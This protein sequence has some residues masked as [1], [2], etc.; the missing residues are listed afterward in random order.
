MSDGISDGM[1]HVDAF[2]RRALDLFSDL[3]DEMLQRAAVDTQAELEAAG[4]E[5][6]KLEEKVEKLRLRRDQLLTVVLH[7][8]KKKTK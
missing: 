5:L 1:R 4:A 3:S 6:Q 2:R 7:R 8:Q